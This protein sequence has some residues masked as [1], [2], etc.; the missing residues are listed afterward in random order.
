MDAFEKEYH[1]WMLGESVNQYSI[2]FWNLVSDGG[3]FKRK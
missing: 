2:K 3:V 1:L